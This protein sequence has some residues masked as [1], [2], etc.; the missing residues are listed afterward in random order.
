MLN[1]YELIKKQQKSWANNQ[2]IKYDKK[3]YVYKLEDNLYEPMQPVSEEE[4][5]AGAGKE[6]ENK[7]KALH[8]SAALVCNFFHY[9]RYKN[10]HIAINSL[11]IS[12][13][14]SKM[15]FEKTYPKP[16][17]IP[18]IL[19]HLDAEFSGKNLR[20]TAIESKFCEPY[21]HNKNKTIK[22]AYIENQN[23]WGSLEN[24]YKLAQQIFYG[25]IKYKRFDASQLLK[26]ILCLNYSYPHRNYYLIYLWYEYPSL[27]SDEHINELSN[28]QEIVKDEVNFHIMTYQNL[29]R[30]VRKY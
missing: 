14:Y 22:K 13:Q 15:V 10:I 1:T 24:C 30:K 25:K 7:M 26:D 20:P 8:S 6:L 9:W 19:P 2:D 4:F 29:F 16:T 17:G 5:H 28:F 18:G 23:V 12:S 21:Y 11:G 27:E 3:G